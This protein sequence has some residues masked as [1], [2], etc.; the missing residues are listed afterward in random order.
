MIVTCNLDAICPGEEFPSDGDEMTRL[1]LAVTNAR[2]PQQR[3]DYWVLPIK[4]L[5]QDPCSVSIALTSQ[6]TAAQS[7]HKL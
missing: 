5:V 6:S 4:E 7:E 2:L 1:S 3:A